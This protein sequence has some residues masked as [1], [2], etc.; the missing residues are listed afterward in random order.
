MVKMNWIIRAGITIISILA[1][2]I[3]IFN[4]FIGAFTGLI[5]Q[6]LFLVPMIISLIF[7][8][9]YIFTNSILGRKYIVKF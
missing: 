4:N 5:E 8:A 2:A 3:I 1:L 9:S 7:S 6:P